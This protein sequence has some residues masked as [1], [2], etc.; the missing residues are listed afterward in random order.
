MLEGKLDCRLFKIIGAETV[1]K[2][3]S[4][5]PRT[6]ITKDDKLGGLE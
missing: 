5:F 1:Y 4:E 2:L 6:A 3:G